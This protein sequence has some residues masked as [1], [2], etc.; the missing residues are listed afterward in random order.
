MQYYSETKVLEV[1]CSFL[2]PVDK[3]FLDSDRI[4]VL[5]MYTAL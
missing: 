2:T 4:E 3:L 5:I 1:Y